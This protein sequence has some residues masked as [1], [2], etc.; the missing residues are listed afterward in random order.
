MGGHTWRLLPCA[1]DRLILKKASNKEL[2][3][4]HVCYPAALHLLNSEILI[5]TNELECLR[6]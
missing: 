3:N 6:T 5:R 4:V 2:I 1:L